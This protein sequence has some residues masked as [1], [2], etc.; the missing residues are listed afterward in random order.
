MNTLQSFQTDWIDIHQ[1][2]LFITLF[3]TVF[4]SKISENFLFWKY[5]DT[6]RLGIGLKRE[7]DL[8][9]FYG[10]MPR[11]VLYKG[12]MISAV[13]M[14]DVMVHPSERGAFTRRGAFWKVAST[15]LEEEVGEGKAHSIA[16]GFPTSRAYQLGKRLGLYDAVDSMCEVSWSLE[17]KGPTTLWRA[18]EWKPS[19]ISY[20]CDIWEKMAFSCKHSIIGVR[21]EAWLAQRYLEHPNSP[22]KI[23]S[24]CPKWSNRPEGIIILKEHENEIELIDFF[25]DVS[26]LK[27]Y[28]KAMLRYA[29]S[30]KAKRLFCWITKS[31]VES[32]KYYQPQIRDLDII[33]PFNV[34]TKGIELEQVQNRWWLMGGDTDFK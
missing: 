26:K 25:G 14:G 12:K 30:Q 31:H 3:E 7:H 23:L 1:S 16:F 29:Y 19:D 10:G 28:M 15:Y 8:T 4:G 17:S 24:I 27:K 11:N 13:Q 5:R 34:H 6:H 2:Q 33:I 9:A 21:D 18:R 20:I 22:Y 32:F